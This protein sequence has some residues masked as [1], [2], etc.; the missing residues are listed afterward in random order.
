MV[1]ATGLPPPEPRPPT[2]FGGRV[3]LRAE[4]RMKATILGGYQG[5]RTSPD[6]HSISLD[7]LGEYLHLV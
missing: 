1:A 6:T 3:K 4:W 2:R 7:G 5:G